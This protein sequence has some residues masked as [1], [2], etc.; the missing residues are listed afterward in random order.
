MYSIFVYQELEK[1]PAGVSG[2]VTVSDQR[3]YVLD[4][5]FTRQKI[6]EIHGTLSEVCGEFTMA[7]RTFFSLG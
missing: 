7:R 6:P 1:E 3:S 2:T 5:N 4:R